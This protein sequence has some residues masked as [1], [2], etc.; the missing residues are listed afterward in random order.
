MISIV[1]ETRLHVLLLIG[2]SIMVFAPAGK[3]GRT[4]CRRAS[5]RSW[6]VA[7]PGGRR[8]T[9]CAALRIG[10]GSSVRAVWAPLWFVLGAPW[11]V[12]GALV[13]TLTLILTNGAAGLQLVQVGCGTTTAALARTTRHKDPYLEEPTANHLNVEGAVP[14]ERLGGPRPNLVLLLEALEV[15]AG[16]GKCGASAGLLL[17]Q[18]GPLQVD[19]V[20]ALALAGLRLDLG[21]DH[22]ALL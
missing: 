18:D 7:G 22:C 4:C 17:L 5:R 15:R 12:R 11:F 3:R 14:L 10:V 9:V 13:L 6:S 20:D 21:V 1:R 2:R 16:I 8:V 19:S